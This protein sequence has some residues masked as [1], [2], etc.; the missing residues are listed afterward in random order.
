MIWRALGSPDA[1]DRWRAAHS[2]RSFGKIDRWEIIDRVVTN[3]GLVDAG[4]FQANELPF[5]YMHARLWLLIALA[6]M[7]K[8]YPSRIARYKEE[9]LA[10]VLEEGEPHVLIRQ[11]ARRVLLTCFEAGRLELSS[12][13]ERRVRR[14]TK[15]PHQRLRNR[16]RNNGGFYSSLSNNS[17]NAEFEFLLDNDFHKGDVDRLSQIFGQSCSKVADMVREIARAIDPNAKSMYDDGGRKS[18]SRGRFYRMSMRY[19]T[20]GQQ[21]GWHFSLYC[22]G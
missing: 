11:F 6:R 3:I 7:A 20:Y 5:F 16:L 12:E 21:L 9:L 4:P 15:S 2:L 8:E 22:S 17:A 1:V 19:H 10:I 13:T 14:A 18:D